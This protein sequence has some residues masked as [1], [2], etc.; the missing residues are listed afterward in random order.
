[1]ADWSHQHVR[2]GNSM[3]RC[4]INLML[5]MNVIE[6]CEISHT[7]RIILT[8]ISPLV[9]LNPGTSSQSDS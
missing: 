4:F 9:L 2:S 5:M 7:C 1:M 8:S 3:L 6:T